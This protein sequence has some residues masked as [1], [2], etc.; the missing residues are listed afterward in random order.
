MPGRPGSSGGAGAGAG[1]GAAGGGGGGGG[2]GAAAAA[3]AS[4]AACAANTADRPS[5]ALLQEAAALARAAGLTYRPGSA[6]AAIEAVAARHAQGAEPGPRSP[7]PPQR[8]RT[9][10]QPQ[11]PRRTAGRARPSSAGLGPACV[12]RWSADDAPPPPPPPPPPPQPPAPAAAVDGAGRAGGCGGGD[13]AAAGLPPGSA[14]IIGA[15]PGSADERRRFP[16]FHAHVAKLGGGLLASGPAASAALSVDAVRWGWPARGA[17][18]AAAAADDPHRTGRRRPHS[19]AAAAAAAVVR[20][21]AADGPPARASRR[22]PQSAAAAG[23][24]GAGGWPAVGCASVFGP[25]PQPRPV[26]LREPPVPSWL[27]P[28]VVE[29]LGA[30]TN[31]TAGL[32]AAEGGSGGGGSGVV[33]AAATAARE[34]GKGPAT[35]GA[36]EARPW[37][38]SGG[39]SWAAQQHRPSTTSSVAARP[40]CPASGIAAG[41][42]G[43][44]WAADG[45]GAAAAAAAVRRRRPPSP[46]QAG[47]A[48]DA[49]AEWPAVRLSA[50]AGSGGQHPRLEGLALWARLPLPGREP[51]GREGLRDI[52]SALEAVLAEAG[53]PAPPL[54]APCDAAA[55]WSAAEQ[56]SA[57]VRP[58]L[59]VWDRL[60][61]E[62]ARQASV[63][64][65]PRG[66]LLARALGRVQGLLADALRCCDAVWRGAGEGR[67]EA[68]RLRAELSEAR[69]SEA[70]A[71]NAATRR[72][73]AASQRDLESL[74]ER[75]RRGRWSAISS[76]VDAARAR[77]GARFEAELAA[78]AGAARRRGAAALAELREAAVAAAARACG[79]DA[80]AGIEAELAELEGQLLGEAA[81]PGGPA[82]ASDGAETARSD[83]NAAAGT[84]PA[85]LPPQPPDAAPGPASQQQQQPHPQPHPHQQSSVED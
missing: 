68:A 49:E 1:A 47:G 26:R 64:C 75:M 32:E 16:H 73:L 30:G 54:R 77:L 11:R 14:L 70:A 84:E 36:S 74:T 60:L 55:P 81:S 17:T 56:A 13:A 62:L 78:A 7:A 66:A 27:V 51:V 6:V 23:C 33:N 85:V 52:A 42:G 83:S 9:A 63:E 28:R 67:A 15:D 8:P 10:A 34:S 21:P 24:S 50:S 25:Q 35:A 72:A 40:S 41:T 57:L 20:G 22:R 79:A 76:E 2:G 12:V 31:G 65:A 58:E 29:P 59:L 69:A 18:A 53:A 39:S 82:A 71:D 37:T 38:A 80:A 4:A 5:Q 45:T 46:P 61:S 48:S 3:S 44:G 19:A 43:W